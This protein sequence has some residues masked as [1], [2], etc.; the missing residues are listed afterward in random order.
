MD[1]I[2][3]RVAYSDRSLRIRD[4]APASVS[5]VSMTLAWKQ[6][7]QRAFG[8]GKGSE[9]DTAWTGDRFKL[10]MSDHGR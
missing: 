1:T 3:A 5:S 4:G 6:H 10:S 8:K 7:V 9:F 2:N